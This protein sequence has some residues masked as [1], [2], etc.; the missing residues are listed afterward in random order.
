MC[1]R[2]SSCS[3]YVAGVLM[4]SS[5]CGRPSDY[6][7]VVLFETWIKKV[8]IAQSSLVQSSWVRT[9][10]RDQGLDCGDSCNSFRLDS[11]HFFK[12][13]LLSESQFPVYYCRKYQWFLFYKKTDTFSG[14]IIRRAVTLKTIRINIF[15]QLLIQN[16]LDILTY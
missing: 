13:S 6:V 7:N 3:W 14:W 16:Q 11:C 4:G 10:S 9:C 8:L 1:Q 5:D 2:C 15:S 12:T